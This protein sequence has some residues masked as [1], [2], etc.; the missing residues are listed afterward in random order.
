[1]PY[2]P[3]IQSEQYPATDELQCVSVY[4]PAGDEY[5]ALLAGF[6]SLLCNPNSY[7]EPDSAQVD[8]LVAVFDTA[9]AEINWNGCGIPPECEHMDSAITVFANDMEVDQGNAIT[10]GV[11]T[12]QVHAFEVSQL[13]ATNGQILR[14]RR[15][16]AA[17]TYDFRLCGIRFTDCGIQKLQIN[18]SDGSVHVHSPSYDFYGTLSYNYTVT[19]TFDIDIDGYTSFFLIT[20]GKNSSSSSYRQRLTYMTMH[21]VP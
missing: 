6:F 13:T 17:G 20:D 16:M 5:K 14:F 18:W 1:M 2:F 19:G 4:L 10:I 9:Y 3:V 11:Q 8:G 12:N 21:R 7:D 15:Y